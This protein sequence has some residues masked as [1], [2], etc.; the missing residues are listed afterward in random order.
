MESRRGELEAALAELLE[1]REVLTAEVDATDRAATDSL[2]V[3]PPRATNSEPI[4]G[5]LSNLE[6]SKSP[7]PTLQESPNDQATRVETISGMAS[8][9]GASG[10]SSSA[11]RNAPLDIR[12]ALQGKTP[13]DPLFPQ[14]RVVP[15]PPEQVVAREQTEKR[16][17]PNLGGNQLRATT[18]PSI[19]NVA[20][21]TSAGNR[22]SLEKSPAKA[23]GD[24]GLLAEDHADECLLFSYKQPM[25]V[26]HVEGPQRILVGRPASYRITLLNQGDT[27]ADS[28]IVT[29][30]IPAWAEVVDA[31]SSRGIVQ[32]AG[33]AGTAGADTT[34]DNSLQWRIQQLEPNGSQS[35]HLRLVPHRG[36]PMQLGVSWVLSP[37]GSA[38]VVEV[39]EPKLQMAIS[40]P[41][42]VLFGKPQRYQLTLS[43]PGTGIA[44]EVKIQ[45]V[46][47]GGNVSSATT[48]EIGSLQPGESQSIDL[49]LT[50]REAGD[51]Q[52]LA[53]AS[54]AGNLRTE[55]TK[56]L[57]CRKP[58]LELDW[59]GPD[60][61]YAGMEATYF[62]RLR[63]SGT[64]PLEP[65]QLKLQLP[66]GVKY[67]EA[68]E[69]E[70]FDDQKRHITWQLTGLNPREEKFVQVR[71]QLDQAGPCV[72]QLSARTVTG[73]LQDEKTIETE[74][75]VLADL[76]LEVNDPK[77]PVPVGDSAIYEIRVTNRGTSQAQ[78]VN[79]VGL[80]SDGIDPVSVEGAQYSIRDGRVSFQTIKSLP[81]GR[82]I[83]LRILAKAAQPGMHLFRAEVVCQELDIKLSSEETTRF[84]QDKFRWDEGDTP[85]M[86]ERKAVSAPVIRR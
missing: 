69:G 52:V 30:R 57:F 40:G 84:F 64:A 6:Q 33:L 11:L 49:E 31:T 38:V 25:I 86:A 10:R 63:N 65:L 27:A 18:A 59:R 71:C 7:T 1:P 46:P 34:D 44:E 14:P 70:S 67:V 3:T 50:A 15:A 16:P 43:N 61:K 2:T 23:N 36:R 41:D 85:Y 24:E 28:M 82:D 68:S 37:V 32:K 17:E 74:V 42:D 13:Q 53:M 54:A 9:S 35:L 66:A 48:H 55:T 76:K 8:T 60:S 56:Q 22:D 77:G 4:P 58:E 51:L 21:S 5:F 39:Q 20:K 83:V 73:E 79:I 19:P 62:F 78:G 29:V 81:A 80:F 72:M 26:S 12:R 45:L 47:P 75:L